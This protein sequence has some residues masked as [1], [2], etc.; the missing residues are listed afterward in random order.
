MLQLQYSIQSL[1]ENSVKI[2]AVLHG[3]TDLDAEGRIQGSSDHPLNDT[4]KAQ[5][6]D[7]AEALQSKGIDTIMSPPQKRAVETAEIIAGHLDIPEGKMVKGMKLLERD[8]GEFEGMLTS[9][10]D[11]L[12]LCSWG[13]NV[14]TPDGETIKET[15]CLVIPYMNNMM[16]LVFKGKTALLVVSSNVLRVLF[17]YFHGLPE[18]GKDTIREL[19]I[20]EVYEFDTDEIPPEMLDSQAIISKLNPENNQGSPDRVL[21]QQEIDKIIADIATKPD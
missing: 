2:F 7:T 20:C 17:Y 14:A 18:A 13:G 9:E 4:G 12:A 1:G 15:A 21:S 19:D 3:Q 10:V 16:K 8:F 5:A 11:I 6:H